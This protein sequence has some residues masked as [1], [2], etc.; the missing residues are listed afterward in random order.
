MDENTKPEPKHFSY[1]LK[2]TL[3][4]VIVITIAAGVYYY[5]LSKKQADNKAKSFIIGMQQNIHQPP[6]TNIDQL[7]LLREGVTASYLKDA[8]DFNIAW[9]YVR[10]EQYDPAFNIFNSLLSEVTTSTT[11]KAYILDAIYL[12]TIMKQGVDKVAFVTAMTKSSYVSKVLG[13]TEPQSS[14]PFSKLFTLITH[15]NSLHQTQ[16]NQSTLLLDEIK[17]TILAEKYHELPDLA[18]KMASIHD[19]SSDP[20]DAWSERP[21]QFNTLKSQILLDLARRVYTP[22]NTLLSD[23]SDISDIKNQCAKVEYL[24]ATTESRTSTVLCNTFYQGIGESQLQKDVQ[25]E[26]IAAY[27]EAEQI[28]NSTENLIKNLIEKLKKPL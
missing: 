14:I 19:I 9:V 17:K 27:K 7:K 3:F 25:K 21:T 22:E 1:T 10:N 5:S 8:I 15:A 13:V 12:Q 24:Y 16:F 11:T 28:P 20:L 2:R 26:H 18:K 23:I 6:L 4:V